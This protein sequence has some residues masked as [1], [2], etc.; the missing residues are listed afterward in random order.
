VFLP[1]GVTLNDGSGN[2]CQAFGGYHSEIADFSGFGGGSGSGSGS[3]SAM[4]PAGVGLV[5]ALIPRCAGP[6]GEG[7]LDETTIATSHEL[8]EASTD[9]HPYTAAGYDQ[10]DNAHLAWRRTPGAELGDMCEYLEN[11]AQP[12][13]GSFLVQR[14]W[15]NASA[16]AGHDPCVPAL[17]GAFVAAAPALPDTMT[18][19]TRNGGTITTEGVAVDMGQ[20]QT[21]EVDVFADA[22]TTDTASV[23]AMDVAQ[24]LGTGTPS[25]EFQWDRQV[26]GNGTKLNLMVTRV[27][28]GTGRPNEFVVITKHGDKISTLW[29]GYVGGM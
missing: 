8:V 9:P 6:A 29:W 2:S 27:K 19:T 7:P 18:I 4:P 10:I 17:S 20:T 25:L 28:A 11:A 14:T 1:A 26:G 12:L 3:G 15:S 5:Y 22:D 21:V 16:A 13:V 23:G 24:F